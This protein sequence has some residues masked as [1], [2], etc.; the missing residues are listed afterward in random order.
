MIEEYQIDTDDEF[1]WKSPA[2]WKESRVVE[3]LERYVS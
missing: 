3:W 1:F 2:E